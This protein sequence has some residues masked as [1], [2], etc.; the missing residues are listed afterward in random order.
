M[1]RVLKADDCVL[2]SMR[3]HITT[4]YRKIAWFFH[5]VLIHFDIGVSVLPWT[6]LSPDFSF[7]ANILLVVAERLDHHCFP[8]SMIHEVLHRF[9][10][11][12]LGLP[13]SVT[14]AYSGLDV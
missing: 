4:R 6:A 9:K 2:F 10:A 1:F 8:A 12:S 3:R 7:I 13:K 11:T 14:Q 5:R